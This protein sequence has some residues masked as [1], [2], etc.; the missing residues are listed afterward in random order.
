MTSLTVQRVPTSLQKETDVFVKYKMKR[1]LTCLLLRYLSSVLVEAGS[2]NIKGDACIH[3]SVG[4]FSG[5]KGY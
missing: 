3:S 2:K 1:I 5:L 4:A